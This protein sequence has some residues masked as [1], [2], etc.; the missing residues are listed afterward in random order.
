MSRRM[1]RKLSEAGEFRESMGRHLSWAPHASDHQLRAI[2]HDIIS[3]MAA[4]SGRELRWLE[5]G[6]T[7]HSLASALRRRL[8]RP[9]IGRV[10]LRAGA[11]QPS[12][13]EVE[14]Q[15]RVR[16]R[17][18]VRVRLRVRVM[19]GVRARVR[20]R[21]R[22]TS[23]HRTRSQAYAE[24]IIDIWPTTVK[25]AHGS[26]VKQAHEADMTIFAN[27]KPKPEPEPEP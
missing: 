5:T 26:I 13:H 10:E 9:A 22:V 11:R 27:P 18:S 23:A 24:T 2:L 7:H 15:A 6:S 21:V 1:S 17:V 8:S 20:V 4:A 14:P 12:E 25:E 3:S 19:V 16:D